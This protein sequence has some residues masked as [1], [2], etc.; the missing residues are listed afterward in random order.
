MM[1]YILLV[2]AVIGLVG[3]GTF[4]PGHINTAGQERPFVVRVPEDFSTIQAAIDAVAEGGTVL[5][6]PGLYKENLTITKSVRLVGVDQEQVDIQAADE[7]KPIIAA[8][9]KNLIQ[10]YFEGFTLGDP[11]VTIEQLLLT[12]PPS[13]PILIPPRTGLYIRGPVQTLMRKVMVLGQ[14]IAGVLAKYYGSESDIG[15]FRLPSLTVLE[16]VHLARNG[17]G[18]VLGGEAQGLI[19]RSM[20]EENIGGVLGLGNAVFLYQNVIRRNRHAGVFVWAFTEDQ[21]MGEIRENEITENGIGVYLTAKRQG[22]RIYITQNRFM[23][24]RYGI[25]IQHPACPY[26]TG[27][28]LPKVLEA[29]APTQIWGTMNEF[30][31]SIEG[32][33]C[34]PDY[35]WPPRFRK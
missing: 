27:E 19:T 29:S 8:T 15:L 24:N 26:V 31:D 22:G 2:T 5:I 11:N 16:G 28:T 13:I 3:L 25:V 18:L 20:I 21:L 14:Q 17:A 6:G 9:S 4:A 10:V 35:P 30:H 33:L 7:H 1:R 32:D 34:P 23:K 12:P